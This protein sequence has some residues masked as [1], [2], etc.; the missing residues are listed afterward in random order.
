MLRLL[1]EGLR[2]G[3]IAERLFL[4]VATIRTHIQN[5]LN[6]LEAGSQEKAVMIVRRWWPRA[7]AGLGDGATISDNGRMARHRAAAPFRLLYVCTGNI[8]RSPFAEIITRHVLIGRLGGRAAS[9]FHI[10]SAGVRAVVGSGMHPDSRAELE[11]WNL[12]TAPQSGSRPANSAPRWWRSPIW[13][14]GPRRGTGRPSWNGCPRRLP[15]TFSLR[16]FA[17]L[18]EAVDD[19]ELPDLPVERAQALVELARA[20]RGL[21]PPPEDG[22]DV[23]DP[24]GGPQEAHHA[25]ATLIRDAVQRITDVML[26]RAD[27]GAQS[28]Q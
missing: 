27:A 13:C 6:K 14:S 15:I 1:D 11:P 26:P 12:H 8:C 19:A 18:A 21:V 17:R 4:S 25:A 3:E 7:F 9:R 2:A 24:I 16:E 5:V 23:P 28:A 22:D 20:Q 10:S